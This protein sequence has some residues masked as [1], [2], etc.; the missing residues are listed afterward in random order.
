MKRL[1]IGASRF[2]RM[3]LKAIK[4]MDDPTW[5]HLGDSQTDWKTSFKNEW[6]S[7]NLHYCARIL[8]RTINPRYSKKQLNSFYASTDFRNFYFQIHDRLDFE[9]NTFDFIFSEHFFEHLFLEEAFELIK[10]C[11]RILKPHGVIRIVVPDADLRTYIKREPISKIPLSH[12]ESHKTRWSIY[13]LPL[14]IK[15]AGLLPH[16]IV[17]CDKYGKFFQDFPS[18]SESMYSQSTDTES[19][20][21]LDYIQRLNSLIVDGVKTSD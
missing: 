21:S 14:V 12:P 13:S 9:D 2:E 16:P 19:I 6:G 3:P 5:I 17:Y 20:F 7:G 11:Y 15:L 1:N 10:E 18:K 4:A 8:Y